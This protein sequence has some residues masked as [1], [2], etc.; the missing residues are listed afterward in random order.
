MKIYPLMVLLMIGSLHGLLAQSTSDQ[1]SLESIWLRYEF[2]PNGP[3]AFRWMEDDQYYS[4]LAE[5]TGIDRYNIQSGQKVDAILD[6]AQLS[7]EVPETVESYEFAEGEQQLLLASQTESIYRRSSQEFV[8]VADR[9]SKKVQAIRSGEKIINAAFSPDGSKVGFVL[10]NNV[11]FT[12][13]ANGAETQVTTDGKRNEIINGLTD[14][15][16]EEEFA[17]V[18]AF[19]WSP[20]GKKIAFYRFDESAVREFQMPIYGSLYPDPYVFKYPKAGEDNAVVSIHI[21][22]LDSG[23]TTTVDIGEET[24]QYIARIKWVNDNT[25]GLMRLNRLQNQLDLLMADAATGASRTFLTETS[26]TYIREATDDKWH[27]LE[28]GEL[29][30]QSEMEGYNH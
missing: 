16:Y 2:Y 13:L 12:D 8:Y 26:D 9:S 1:V 19:K 7:G 10:D 29:I 23:K 3:S 11:Y 20:D 14:W 15:V 25:L 28:S 6:F 27:F 5:G 24:D 17:F 30:W 18:D 21:Y 22:D 4:V